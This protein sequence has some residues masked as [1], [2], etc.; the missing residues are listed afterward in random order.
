MPFLTIISSFTN[1]HWFHVQNSSQQHHSSG[2]TTALGIG[3][4]CAKRLG[5][6][7]RLCTWFFGWKNHGPKPGFFFA[8]KT[9]EFDQLEVRTTKQYNKNVWEVP[10]RIVLQFARLRLKTIHS[11]VWS[12]ARHLYRRSPRAPWRADQ[13]G[14]SSHLSWIRLSLFNRN[15]T[16]F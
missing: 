9:K 4:F 13:A 15:F 3:P 10:T 7:P 8:E 11:H 14:K 1:H 2:K 5:E 16:P 6:L 12:Y